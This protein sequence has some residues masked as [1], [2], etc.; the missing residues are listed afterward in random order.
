MLITFNQNN[1]KDMTLEKAY[2]QF[3]LYTKSKNLSWDTIDTYDRC[4]K[5]FCKFLDILRDEYNILIDKC[6]QVNEDLMI[7]YTNYML[8]QLNIKPVTINT[9]ITHIKI[10]MTYCMKRRIYQTTI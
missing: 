1:T 4:Y 2:Y 7:D 5:Y 8:D 6:N 3:S 9:R 10:F